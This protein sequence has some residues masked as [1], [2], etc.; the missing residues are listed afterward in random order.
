MTNSAVIHLK[1]KADRSLHRRHPWIFS[2][3]V[4]RVQGSAQAGDAVRVVDSQGRF[5]AWGFYNP[6]SGLPIRVADWDEDSV[7]DRE[8]LRRRIVES[9][10]RRGPA[11][12]ADHPGGRRLVFAESDGLPGLILDRYADGLVIQAQIPGL[13]R[14]KA[15]AARIAAEH[16][17]ARWVYER[18]EGEARRM[19]GLDPAAGPL[20]GDPPPAGGVTIAENGFCFAV[21]VQNGQKTGFF[22]D[23][24]VNRRRAAAWTEGRRALDC[25]AH[26][27][28][29]T[30]QAYGA[31]AASVVRVDSSAEAAELGH[32]NLSLNHMDQRPGQTIVG[33]AFKTLRRF[34]DQN[35]TFDFIFMDPPKLAPSRGHAQ[36]AAR[37]YKDLNLLALKM[38]EPGG[39]LA[40]FSCSRAVDPDLFQKIVFGAA[41]DAGRTAWIVDRFAQ[42]PDHPAALHF[43]EAGYLKGLLVAV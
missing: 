36:K 32:R 23:Q 15:E 5:A 26:T 18:S 3:A 27:N 6:T 1:A 2:G 11:G 22:L 29:F 43:P 28:A 34:R 19:E 12:R 21:D 31:G 14:I 4:D 10:D 35:H 33:D 9:I 30:V 40:T 20:W 39:L 37:A 24:R 13:D 42:S 41:L 16:V 7:P 17:G 8:W 38:L 25:F